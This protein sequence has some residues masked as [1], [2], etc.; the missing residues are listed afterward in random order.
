MSYTIEQYVKDAMQSKKEHDHP[1]L[2]LLDWYLGLSGET[3]ELIE[4]LEHFYTV[5]NKTL[6]EVIKE[7]GDCIWYFVAFCTDAINILDTDYSLYKNIAV[8][9]NG[10]VLDVQNAAEGMIILCLKI[11]EELKHVL[12]H[13]ADDK[14]LKE[15]LSAYWLNLQCVIKFSGIKIDA[16][17]EL[18][19]A[20]LQHRYGGEYTHSKSE[21]RH[22]E[23]VKF[24]DTLQYKRIMK[25]ALILA[26]NFN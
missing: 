26:K 11:A 12:F 17:M 22:T 5:D 9:D 4:A 8:L 16:V 13:K 24:T 15:Y 6:P 1:H 10:N 14:K 19:A 23:E 18:N 2:T 21:V 7:M 25:G 3:E 20:K